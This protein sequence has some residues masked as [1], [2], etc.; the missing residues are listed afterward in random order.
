MRHV[1]TNN[2][3]AA[4]AFIAH[5]HQETSLRRLNIACKARAQALRDALARHAPQLCPVDLQGGSALWVSAPRAFDTR[6]LSVRL[7]QQ[8]AIIEPGDVL[9]ASKRVP[10][11]HVRI[12]HSSIPIDRIQPGV[13]IIVRELARWAPQAP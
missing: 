3:Q 4:G 11:H 6:E 12:G 10:R 2:Q 8:G 1:P 5:G 13:R 7:Y 9:F